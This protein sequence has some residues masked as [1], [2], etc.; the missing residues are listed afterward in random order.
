MKDMKRIFLLLL[1]FAGVFI[2]VLL[3]GEKN[4]SMQKSPIN[5]GKQQ[6]QGASVKLPGYRI[7]KTLS[8]Y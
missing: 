1:I 3:P 6:E 7:L 8:I 5:P 4:T 2:W